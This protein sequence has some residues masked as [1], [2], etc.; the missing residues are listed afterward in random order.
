M[1]GDINLVSCLTQKNFYA[2]NFS[3]QKD[4]FKKESS[5]AMVTGG[6]SKGGKAR[7]NDESGVFYVPSG[8]EEGDKISHSEGRKEVKG[9]EN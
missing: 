5:L 4:L 7:G 2:N 1:K 9:R 6:G 8:G 3:V